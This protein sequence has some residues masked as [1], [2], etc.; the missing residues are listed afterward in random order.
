MEKFF[1]I[2][3][4]KRFMKRI[5]LVVHG[6]VQGV[7]YREF[8][9][10]EAEKLGVVGFVRNLSNGSVEVVA[11]GKEDKL[12]E[13]IKA[14]RKGSFLSFVEKVDEKPENATGEFEDFDVRF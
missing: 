7:F 14:C 9:K 1:K 13:L 3:I 12:K 6:R 2:I 4:I 5:H 8:V 10:K 11:E